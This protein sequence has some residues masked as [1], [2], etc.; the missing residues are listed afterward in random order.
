M[1]TMDGD[2]E[3][4]IRKI[5]VMWKKSVKFDFFLSFQNSPTY[6]KNRS[7]ALLDNR[8]SCFTG[9]LP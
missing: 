3:V 1:K 4:E 6:M 2:F 8:F 9:V 5:D 7:I